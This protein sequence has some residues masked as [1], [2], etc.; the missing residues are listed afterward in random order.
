MNAMRGRWGA[1]MAQSTRVTPLLSS[2]RDVSIVNGWDQEGLRVNECWIDRNLA[3]TSQP[4]M[5]SGTQFGIVNFCHLG[6]DLTSPP[7]RLEA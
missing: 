2:F 5:V 1:M 7:A 6:H 3:G 4:A